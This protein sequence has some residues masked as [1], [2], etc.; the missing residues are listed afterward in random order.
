[1]G[2]LNKARTGGLD[3][4]FG[5]AEAAIELIHQMGKGEGFGVVVGQGIARMKQYFAKEFGADPQILQDIGMEHKGLEF[6]EYMTKE[7]LAQQGGYGFTLKGPQHDEAW[8]IFEDMARKTIPSFEDKANAL[9]WFPYWRTWFGLNGLC[10]ILWNDVV[11]PENKEIPIKDDKGMLLRA[12]IPKHVDW[13]CKYYEY[14]TGKKVTE[15]DIIEDSRRVYNFQR[16]FAIRQGKGLKEH[17]SNFPYRAMGPVTELEY[18]SR[19]DRYDQQL[20]QIGVDISKKTIQEKI[21]ILRQHREAQYSK[22]QEVV[23]E[24][25]GW[26]KNGC[27]SIEIVKK[28]GIDFPDVLELIKPYQ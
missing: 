11:P 3:L 26:T 1:M 13:Y 24:K 4:K 17:D 18:E 10:K 20:T 2:I 6:S 5:N 19:K 7:S 21:T 16:I 27:P 12:R 25:R 28:L 14:T 22:L 23:Y 15:A 9:C 8:L